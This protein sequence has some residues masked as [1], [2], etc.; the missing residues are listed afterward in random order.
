MSNIAYFF[1]RDEI[2]YLYTGG[3][4]YVTSRSLD[5]IE[6][7]YGGRQFYRANR[8]YII[9]REFI[10]E[11]EQFFAR[12]LAVKLIVPVSEGIIVSKAKAT[13]FMKWLEG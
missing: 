2:T 6:Q 7:T 9:N 8:Q 4:E 3:Q 1:V 12:K 5:E 10:K 11:V 13:N